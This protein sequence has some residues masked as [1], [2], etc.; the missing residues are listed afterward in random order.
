MPGYKDSILQIIT[1]SSDHLSAEQVFLK[2]KEQYPK[3]V[4]ATIY[5]NLNALCASGK[6]RRITTSGGPDLYDRAMPHDHLQCTVCGT[7]KDIQLPDLS[8]QI[9]QLIDAP[10]VGYDLKVQWICPECSKKQQEAASSDD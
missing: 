3:V 1:D 5:N 8:A 2:L 7:L 9:E 6:I 10:V 4:Q